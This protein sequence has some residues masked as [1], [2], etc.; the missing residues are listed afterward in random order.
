MTAETWLSW[1]QH[2]NHFV[3]T[4]EIQKPVALF[5]D[6]YAAHLTLDAAIY[7][8]ENDIILM[9][10]K[11]NA[12][13]ILQPFDVGI[14][15]EMKAAWN[16]AVRDWISNGRYGEVIDKKSFP[17]IFKIAWESVAKEETARKAFY[18]SGI[19]PFDERNVDYTRLVSDPSKGIKKKKITSQ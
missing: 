3:N 1:L 10:L 2:F 7:A 17:G 11:Q 13:F 19:F 4:K 14:F 15:S 9:T 6:G 12:T 8:R 5:I 16:N 18:R